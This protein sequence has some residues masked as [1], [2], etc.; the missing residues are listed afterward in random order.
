[1]EYVCTVGLTVSEGPHQPLHPF[2]M[3]LSGSKKARVGG[4][5]EAEKL[6][7]DVGKRSQHDQSQLYLSS[8]TRSIGIKSPRW[9]TSS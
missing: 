2:K 8:G 6:N 9:Q 3:L 4:G 1:M 5:N 7:I